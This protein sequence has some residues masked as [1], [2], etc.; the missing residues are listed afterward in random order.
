MGGYLEGHPERSTLAGLRSLRTARVL[1]EGQASSPLRLKAL[2]GTQ[3][4]PLQVLTIEPGCYFIDFL[5]DRALADPERSRFTLSV[6]IWYSTLF[7]DSGS[8]WRRG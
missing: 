4:G 3:P 1:A 8:L 2:N 6:N 5:I 7:D